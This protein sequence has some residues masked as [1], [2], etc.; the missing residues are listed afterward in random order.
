HIPMCVHAAIL[1]V[2]AWNMGEWREVPEIL[3]LSRADISV[4]LIT[5]VLTVLADLTVAVEAGMILAA[6]MFVRKV[7]TTTTVARVTSEYVRDGLPHS[8][9]HH[10]IPEGVAVYRIHGPFLFG[11]AEKLD[12]IRGEIEGLSRVVVLRLRNMTAIDATG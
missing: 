11:A 6:L 10:T 9:Q 5:F 1:M 8:L 12:L 3:K 4:W 7:T 2:V